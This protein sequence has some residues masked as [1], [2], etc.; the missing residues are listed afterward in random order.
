MAGDGY[1]IELNAHL[2]AQL[3]EAAR[4]AGLSV[5]AYAAEL[6]SEALG[7]PDWR[8]TKQSLAHYDRTGEFV[9]LD[10]ALAAAKARLTQ[11]LA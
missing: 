3:E 8:E 5:D 10:E 11:R 4:A 2:G 1:R 6:I 7:D 9:D